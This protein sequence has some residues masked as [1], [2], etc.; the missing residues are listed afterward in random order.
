MRSKIEIQ[1]HITWSKWSNFSKEN[2]FRMWLMG[3]IKRWSILAWPSW[4]LSCQVKTWFPVEWDYSHCCPTYLVTAAW[5]Q[6]SSHI[7]QLD[8][9]TLFDFFLKWG[10]FGL[11]NTSYGKET[12]WIGI[13]AKNLVDFI[14]G[15]SK[16]SV[17]LFFQK[18]TKSRGPSLSRVW[19]RWLY[20]GKNGLQG[21]Q[22]CWNRISRKN[23]VDFMIGSSPPSIFVL[24]LFMVLC[25][26]RLVRPT[27]K[28]GV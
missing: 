5:F 20:E 6:S 18:L 10:D 12:R 25:W 11:Q 27:L 22:T 15:S 14:V 1:E 16:P 24:L 19:R 3:R 9:G 7:S 17:F 23:I 8:E 2:T 21:N 4:N 26:G 13:W 28:G